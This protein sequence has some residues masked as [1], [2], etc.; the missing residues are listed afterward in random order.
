MTR[1]IIHN[2]DHTVEVEGGPTDDLDT[3]SAKA[4]EMWEQFFGGPAT[5]ERQS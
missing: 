3:V 5:E 2:Y 4:R 1:V